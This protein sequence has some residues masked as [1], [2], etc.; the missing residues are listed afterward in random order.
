M[1]ARSPSSEA[2]IQ[3]D[4]TGEILQIY[5][6]DENGDLA[7]IA[8]NQQGPGSG[9]AYQGEAAPSTSDNRHW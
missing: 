3:W 7:G 8:V 2:G 9:S 6:N 1:R 5:I 4:F